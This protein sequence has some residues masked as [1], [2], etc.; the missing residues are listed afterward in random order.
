MNDPPKPVCLSIAGLDPS[1]GAGI[2]ADVTTFQA[3]GCYAVAAVTSVTFQNATSVFGTEDQ[4]AAS[5]RRQIEAVLYDLEVSAIKTGMLPTREIV[6][7]IADIIQERKLQRIVVDPVI[8][9]T[10]GYDLIEKTAVQA[11]VERLFPLAVLITPNIPESE[12]ITGIAIESEEDIREAASIMR[13]MG[14]RNVLIK[15]GHLMNTGCRTQNAGSTR[16]AVD[17]LFIGEEQQ[18]FSAEYVDGSVMRG[19]GCILSS[20]IAANLAL[21]NTL[22]DAIALSKEFVTNAIIGTAPNSVTVIHQ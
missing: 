10:S 19:T 11:L 6:E 2:I 20:A 9:S 22:P 7:T 16:M 21:G 14:A 3:F 1:G 17:H 5:V 18:S 15:G 13:E 8:R 12:Q 4:S